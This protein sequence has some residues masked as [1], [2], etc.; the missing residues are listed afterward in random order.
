M[1]RK[2]LTKCVVVLYSMHE[3]RKSSNFS[4]RFIKK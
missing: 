4:T 3:L 1:Y 2:V